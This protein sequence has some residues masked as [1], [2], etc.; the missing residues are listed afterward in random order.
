MLDLKEVFNKFADDYLKFE[1]IENPEY[2]RPDMCAFIMLDKLVPQE[3]DRDMVSAASHDEI[4]LDIDCEELA[5]VATEQ[6]IQTLVRCG[7]RYSED[8][9]CMF[10]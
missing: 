6:D 3:K 1:N 2:H 5:K 8:G 4:W 7:I 10:T 9:L